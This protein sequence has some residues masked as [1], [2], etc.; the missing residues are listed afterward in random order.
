[1]AAEWGNLIYVHLLLNISAV[2]NYSDHPSWHQSHYKTM[3]NRNDIFVTG[4]QYGWGWGETGKGTKL[5]ICLPGFV[6]VCC[7]FFS[8][9]LFF[10][11][12]AELIEITIIYLFYLFTHSINTYQMPTACRHC[13]RHWRFHSKQTNLV[14]VGLLGFGVQWRKTVLFKESNI[15]SSA[16][17]SAVKEMY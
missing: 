15:L 4:L 11:S 9:F 12:S 17:R 7:I 5:L 13:A 3:T 10:V 14:S 1:M 2:E 16:V 8:I 6:V